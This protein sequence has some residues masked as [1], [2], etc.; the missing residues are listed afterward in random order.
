MR[1]LA[2]REAGG[3]RW[4]EHHL[5]GPQHGW[6]HTGTASHWLTVVCELLT[7]L[8]DLGGESGPGSAQ[9]LLVGWCL[10]PP[11]FGSAPL[12]PES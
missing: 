12:A 11:G 10:Q 9:S 6:V 5:A 3:P 2:H 1:E 8:W 4:Q 7:L